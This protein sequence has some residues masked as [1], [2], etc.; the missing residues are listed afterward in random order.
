MCIRDRYITIEMG[1]PLRIEVNAARKLLENEDINP[2]LKALIKAALKEY[3]EKEDLPADDPIDDE[4]VDTGDPEVPTPAPRKTQQFSKKYYSF[5]IPVEII[6]DKFDG[7][8]ITDAKQFGGKI[9]SLTISNRTHTKTLTSTEIQE[10]NSEIMKEQIELKNDLKI[11]GN[12]EITHFKLNKDGEL[13]HITVKYLEDGKNRTKTVRASEM[14]VK[15][16]LSQELVVASTVKTNNLQL[17]ADAG[18]NFRQISELASG[19]FPWYKDTITDKYRDFLAPLSNV[20][21]GI[22]TP[23]GICTNIFEIKPLSSSERSVSHGGKP[24]LFMSAFKQPAYIQDGKTTYYYR[25]GFGID[26]K[27]VTTERRAKISVYIKDGGKKYYLDIS[28]NGKGDEFVEIAQPLYYSDATYTERD[29]TQFCMSFLGETSKLTSTGS[30]YLRNEWC[31]DITL[32]TSMSEAQEFIDQ[33]TPTS[34]HVED[35]D[36]FNC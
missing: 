5:E 21:K 27:L 12:Y 14:T 15:A 36:C 25:F 26:P 22:L 2:V 8:D 19:M 20:I 17:A 30:Q 35:E 34:K 4:P 32:E 3:E 9:T 6:Q 18:R 16:N 10:L 23:K 28:G 13:D 33:D 11:P 1:H 31:V 24:A 7:Y 29:V